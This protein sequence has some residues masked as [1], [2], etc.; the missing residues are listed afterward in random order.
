LLNQF[1]PLSRLF[2]GLL[3]NFTCK[4]KP[5][6][7]L[8]NCIDDGQL[9]SGVGMCSNSTCVCPVGKCGTYCQEKCTTSRTTDSVP[10]ILGTCL[11]CRVC[12]VACPLTDST[13]T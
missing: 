3:K 6:S 2:Y 4:G 11:S 12:R 1:A 8:Y 5:V 10:I 7:A 9:C 13:I